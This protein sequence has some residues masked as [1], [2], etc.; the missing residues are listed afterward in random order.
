MLET[1]LSLHVLV[2]PKHH[3]LQHPWVRRMRRL[4]PELKRAIAQFAFL[5][6]QHVPDCFCPPPDAEFRSFDE[7][8]DAVLALED[9]ELALEF[10]RPLYDHRGKRDPGLLEQPEVRQHALG[11][12]AEIGADPGLAALIFDAPRELAQRVAELL[13]EY[14]EAEFA[15]EWGRVE[16]RLADTVSEAGR[17]IAGGGLFDF[18]ERMPRRLRVDREREEI[19]VDLPH[20]HRVEPSPSN[21][22]LFVP[23]AFAWPH[24]FVNCDE[25]W[26]LSVIY[27][28]PFVA[29]EARAALPPAEL[30]GVLRAVGDH[31]RLRALRLISERPRS[32]Q[33][34]A[35]L[36][37]ISEAGLS[38]HLR[39]LARAGIVESRRDGYYV[40]YRVVPERIAP[41]SDAVLDFLGRAAAD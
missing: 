21:R 39:Q 7:E 16:P 33:E 31:T 34:L 4:R 29:D 3:P 25:P 17:L 2:E 8:L 36:V 24:V 27:P 40:L 10:L 35:P 6:D 32:T 15:S 5:Y 38:K 28:A 26:P 41:L 23:S 30:V 22:L 19:G 37:G 13:T 1:V 9:A 18:L 12:A 20:R 11:R 14:W